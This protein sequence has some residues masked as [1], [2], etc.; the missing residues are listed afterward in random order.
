MFILKWQL[1][2]WWCKFYAS[3]GDRN[4]CGRYLEKGYEKIVVSSLILI[5][6]LIL[7]IFSFLCEKV[8]NEELENQKVMDFLLSINISYIIWFLYL[9][10]FLFLEIRI[11]NWLLWEF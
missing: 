10:Y 3:I 4:K 2:D 1:K 8:Y 6:H 7:K 5:K 9:I 11:F